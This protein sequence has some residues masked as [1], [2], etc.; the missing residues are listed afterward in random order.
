MKVAE[1]IDPIYRWWDRDL[2]LRSF[3]R[4]EVDAILR[5]P[6]NHRCT[7]DTVMWIAEKSGEYSV[8]PRY[9]VARRLSKEQ[10]W[11]ECSKGAVEGGVWKTLWKLKVPNKIKVFGW[12]ARCNILPT[13]VNLSK[14][15]IMEDNRCEVCKTE[16]KTGVHALWNCGMAQDI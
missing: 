15:R 2:I 9:H 13:R 16:P 10:D 14:K 5:I 7:S 1:L 4:G 6:P 11:V 12:R 3:N 8:K